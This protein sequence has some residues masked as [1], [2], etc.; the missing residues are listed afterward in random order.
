MPSSPPPS[1]TRGLAIAPSTKEQ[2]VITAERLF[3]LNGLDGVSLRQISA[4]AGNAN[5]SAVQYHFGTKDDFVQ[6]IFEYRIPGLMRRRRLLA[7]G[8]GPGLRACVEAY[9]LPVLEEAEDV[10]SYY[11]MFLMQLQR[12]GIGEHP[13]DRMPEEF[14]EPTRVFVG[15]VG[16]FLGDLPAELRPTRIEQAMT[17]CTHAC[18]DRQMARRNG[19]PVA[20][21]PLHV[22]ALLDGI[23]GFLT[24]PASP[25]T[26]DALVGAPVAPRWRYLLP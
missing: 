13:F 15:E 10:D 5:N 16:A 4:A 14:K 24:A 12:Y 6:A 1:T 19:A 21:Y 2:L 8:R 11:M 26:L 3:A 7:T 17:I 20:P 23:V 18:A 9:F 25:A 22:A